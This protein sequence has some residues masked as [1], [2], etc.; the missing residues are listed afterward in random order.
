[1]AAADILFCSDE[2]LPCSPE[3]WAEMVFSRYETNI[4][5]IGLGKKGAFLATRDQSIR[6]RLAPVYTRPVVNTI[7]AGDAL[8]SCFL[9]YY[10]ATKNALLALHR[11]MVFA[12][13]KIGERGSADS[14][15]SERDLEIMSAGSNDG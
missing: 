14:F 11:A 6:E 7:G 15:L 8:F 12:S 1:M 4:V 5:V 13:Y 3:E 10:I 9:H 2:L